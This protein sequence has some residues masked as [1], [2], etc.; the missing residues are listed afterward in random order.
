MG[1]LNDGVTHAAGIRIGEC[2]VVPVT[3][4]ILPPYHH[5]EIGS[6]IGYPFGKDAGVCVQITVI[7]QKWHG[8]VGVGV[9]AAEG[10]SVPSGIFDIEVAQFVAYLAV[11]PRGFH[12][13][14]GGVAGALAVFV[15]RQPV[16]VGD[17]RHKGEVSVDIEG[18]AV[19]VQ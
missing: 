19:E 14:R 1:I 13:Y 10:I 8:S 3:R 15:E 18:V 9:P 11:N 7:K 5:R 4:Q 16:T 12:E 2:E 6:R 17:V